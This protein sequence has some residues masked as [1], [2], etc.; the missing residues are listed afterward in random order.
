VSEGSEHKVERKD[1]WP[2]G[3]WMTEPDKV[4]WRTK[5]GLP[6]MIVRSQSGNLCGYVAVPKGHPAYRAD[7]SDERLYDLSVHGGVTYA[8]ACK[9]SIC[10]VPEP[11]E[12]DDV[13]WIG[14][15]CAH[16]GDWRPS[17]AAPYLG[18]LASMPSAWEEYRDIHYVT[19]EVEHLARQLV[20]MDRPP[21]AKET[22]R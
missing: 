17:A 2:E 16:S 5:A 21:H 4:N 18:D 1:W 14:F 10:H 12:P 9:G 22:D 3:P 13:W 15:D 19:R 11:G 20:E 6:G 7:M 8:S